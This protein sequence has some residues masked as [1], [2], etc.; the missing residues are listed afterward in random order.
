MTD[1]TGGGP[2]RPTQFLLPEA[3]VFLAPYPG[4]SDPVEL[5]RT[6]HQFTVPFDGR[7]WTAVVAFTDQALAEE[8]TEK[9]GDT[10]ATLK[11]LAWRTYDELAITLARL[12][13]QGVECVYFD[14]GVAFDARR[15]FPV[16]Y[17]LQLIA[18]RKR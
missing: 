8:Y 2:L 15:F 7:N 13:Q 18:A 6:L 4:P 9:L 14:P 11:P 1:D 17:L 16:S 3:W 10:G 12:A 5:C